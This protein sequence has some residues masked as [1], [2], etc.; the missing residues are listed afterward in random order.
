MH[1]F[2]IDSKSVYIYL[3]DC[4]KLFYRSFYYAVKQVTLLDG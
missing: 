3:D 2:N 4:R 1:Q